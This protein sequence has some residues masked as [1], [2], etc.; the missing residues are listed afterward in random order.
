VIRS[1]KDLG[2]T[3]VL[4]THYLDEAQLLSDRVAIVQAGRIVAEGPPSELT[5]ASRT[6]R[7]SYTRAG[8]RIELDTDDPTEL[9]HRLTGEALERG[10]TLEDLTVTR[11]S[12]EDVYLQLTSTEAEQA[13]GTEAVAR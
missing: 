6:Y 11:P 8:D 13:E 9:L 10:E 7:V 1:L 2:K 3:V 12:L 5:P 4:T